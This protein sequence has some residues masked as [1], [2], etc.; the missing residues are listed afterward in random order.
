MGFCSFGSVVIGSAGPIPLALQH[1]DQ[2]A[3]KRQF[4]FQ[5]ISSINVTPPHLSSLPVKQQRKKPQQASVDNSL[6]SRSSYSWYDGGPNATD[7]PQD[8][9]PNHLQ[10][11]MVSFY[12]IEVIVTQQ[13]AKKYNYSLCSRGMM[14]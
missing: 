5:Q 12:K 11:L 9:P 2:H 10:D 6:S 3:G 4:Q 1:G 8:V 7:V 13:R 14:K